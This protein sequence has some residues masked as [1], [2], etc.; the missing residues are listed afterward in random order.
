MFETRLGMLRPAN[1][2]AE[3]AMREI[4]GKVRVEIKG[5][6]ANQ[7]RRGLYWSVAALVAPLLNDMHGLTLDEQDLH[8]IT[9]DKLRVYDEQVL[10]SGEVYRRRRSTSNRAMNEAERAEFTTKALHLWS[11]WTGVAVETLHTEARDAA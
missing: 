9:R 2:A 4:K 3:E 6:V 1:R 11:T 10:P 8:D 7:R 5:G